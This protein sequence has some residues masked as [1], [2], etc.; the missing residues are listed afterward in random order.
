MRYENLMDL[1]V[2]ERRTKM[3]RVVDAQGYHLRWIEVPVEEKKA[4][5]TTRGTEAI[6]RVRRRITWRF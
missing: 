1:N 6:G 3:M 2:V 5:G 4:S